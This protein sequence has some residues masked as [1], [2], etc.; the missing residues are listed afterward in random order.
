M[1]PDLRKIM[2]ALLSMP[3]SWNVLHGVAEIRTPIFWVITG[4]VP[5]AEKYSVWVKGEFIPK[6]LEEWGKND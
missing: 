4:S 2:E 1:N 3:M 5:A 6:E